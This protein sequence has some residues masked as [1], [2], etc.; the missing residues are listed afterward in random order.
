M[1]SVVTPIR[2][3]K[4]LTALVVPPKTLRNT[5]GAIVRADVTGHATRGLH[6]R[7][8]LKHIV[9]PQILCH[10]NG[11]ALACVLIVTVSIRKLRPSSDL[12]HDL[13][14]FGEIL[15]GI[16]FSDSGGAVAEDDSGSL[17]AKSFAK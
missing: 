10:I 6:P 5:L 4:S 2:F 12:R 7:E 11:E 13:C 16:N 3:S 17:D 14:G 1:C 15:L 9:A 8:S